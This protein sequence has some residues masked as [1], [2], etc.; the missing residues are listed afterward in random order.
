MN[1]FYLI[2]QSLGNPALLIFKGFDW[3]IASSEATLN[4]INGNIDALNLFRNL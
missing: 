3:Y 4:S 2:L 1:E